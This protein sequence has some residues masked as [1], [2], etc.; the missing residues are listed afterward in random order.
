MTTTFCITGVSG[1]IGG[2]LARKLAANQEHRVIGIDIN[3]PLDAGPIRF[4][5]SDI[6]DKGIA[7]I[8]EAEK[9]DVLIHL[10]F[11]TLPEGDAREARSV[12]I[13]G[14]KNILRAT[15][16]AKVRRF[17]LASSAAA[18]G[19]HADNPV[20]MAESQPLRANDFFYYSAHKAEQEKLTGAFAGQH[21]QTETIILRPCVLI[22]PHINNP[23][24]DSLKEKIL[25]FIK[26]RQPPI[27]LIHEDD[28][29]QAFYLAAIGTGTGVFNVAAPGT[30]TYPE[31]AGLMNKKI[32]LLPF[33]LLAALATVGKWLGVSP[34][35]G[36][37]L[38][39]IRNPI[40]IDP[41][42]FAN[43]FGFKPKYD[44]RAAFVNFMDAI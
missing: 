26:G 42:K 31:L 37:T 24:G 44:S 4:F 35:S 16:K 30:V 18:Y 21:P 27:Q 20:P 43:H 12:N 3:P 32:I 39:F 25:I 8:L 22:G 40:V 36:T 10:A 14:T 15:G 34:V 7:E 5:E 41:D 2:L 23:T 17:V 29:A 33:G 6:R 1:Y 28:A 11:Y 38:K 9:V 13:I 19:S